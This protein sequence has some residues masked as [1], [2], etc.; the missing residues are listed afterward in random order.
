MFSGQDDGSPSVFRLGVYSVMDIED[1]FRYEWR[2][3]LNFSVPQVA[4]DSPESTFPETL[5]T[6]W[7]MN[8]Q[9]EFMDFSNLN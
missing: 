9:L 7:T 4:P 2:F 5:E 8:N 6:L 3:F 1:P